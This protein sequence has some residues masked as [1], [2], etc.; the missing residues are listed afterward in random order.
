[1]HLPLS[2]GR[3]IMPGSLLSV[4]FSLM[5]ILEGGISGLVK[6]PGTLSW[7]CSASEEDRF[8]VLIDESVGV[9]RSTIGRYHAGIT[10]FKPFANKSLSCF[11]HLSWM[12]VYVASLCLAPWCIGMVYVL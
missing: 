9:R 11:N 3:M 7:I 5:V 2:A 1:M 4:K 8:L 6:V 12:S 10:K